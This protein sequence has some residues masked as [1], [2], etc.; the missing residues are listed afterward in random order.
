MYRRAGQ[1][2]RGGNIF[3]GQ[4]GKLVNKGAPIFMGNGT[5]IEQNIAPCGD[6]FNTTSAMP[7]YGGAGYPRLSSAPRQKAILATMGKQM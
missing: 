2:I 1:I 3:A 4:A 5:A 7:P 6:F